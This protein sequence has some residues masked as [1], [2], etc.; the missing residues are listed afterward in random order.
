MLVATPGSV[1]GDGSRGQCL[2]PPVPFTKSPPISCSW[3]Y[4]YFA[5]S[6]DHC[7]KALMEE[8]LGDPPQVHRGKGHLGKGS[9]HEAVGPVCPELPPVSKDMGPLWILGWEGG[10]FLQEPALIG[11]WGFITFLGFMSTLVDVST[12]YL[13]QSVQEAKLGCWEMV[14]RAGPSPIHTQHR[15]P[16]ALGE[17]A[18][19]TPSSV[20]WPNSP[21]RQHELKLH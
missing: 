19:R 10:W 7:W 20:G 21:P 16:R 8:L 5:T 2:R 11:A 12:L 17:Q 4:S 15:I 6:Q 14:W 3:F 9:L 1:P 13:L 18:G